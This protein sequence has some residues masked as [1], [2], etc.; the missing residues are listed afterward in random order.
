MALNLVRN[1][2]VFFTTN[3][4]AGTGIINASTTAA[5]TATNIFEIQILDGFTFSQNV[6][7]DTVTLSEAG[8]TPVRGQR[9]FNTSLAP[10]D[11]SF[12]TYIRPRNQTTKITAEE[13]VLW[14][15]MLSDVAIT[16][17]VSLGAVTGVTVSNAGLVSIAGTAITGTLPTVGDIITLAGIATSTPVGND[18]FVNS[19]GT[20]LTSAVGGITIQLT[21]FATVAITAT[22]LTT[23]STVKYTKAAWAESNV[24]YS[25]VTSGVSDKNQLQKFGMLFLV[26]NVL[27]AVDNC[28]LSQVTVDF[29]LDS[30]ATAQWTGQATALRQ[31]ATGLSAN[32]GTF[33]GGAGAD[34]GA[35]SYTAKDTS[36]AYIT[37]KL[38]TISL[39]AVK[40]IGGSIAA[41]DSYAVPITGGSFSVNNNVTYVTPANLGVVNS[42]VTYYTGT[43][44][45][46][47]NVTA[48]L[49]TG[50]IKETGELLADLL[51]EASTTLEPMFALSINIGGTGTT[52]V[53]LDMP[54]VTVGIPSVDVQQVVSTG[55]NFT[56][57]GYIPNAVVANT[58]FDLT[59]A[60]DL[61][62]RYY[63]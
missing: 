23:A 46:S 25:Q 21:N 38:S 27:Y 7:N 53:V 26:D 60:S 31:F 4:N 30:I 61:A 14:N 18:K 63:A 5:Y 36:A 39:V 13:S 48:Y 37:N 1:S 10:V 42:P 50:T 16:T 17:P 2:K 49:R 12:S 35:G 45:I 56:A 24:V 54:A 19:T 8:N 11:F 28:A 58:V 62:V 9:S 34:V 55:I 40:A 33:A 44:A 59:K 3:V 20:V 22:T 51:T 41:G 52:R 57:Q 47:G 15:A 29:G 32:G 6:N 43:R